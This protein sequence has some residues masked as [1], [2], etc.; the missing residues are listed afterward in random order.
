[1]TVNR[2]EGNATILNEQQSVQEFRD[3][4]T[5]TQRVVYGLAITTMWVGL[6]FLALG[7]YCVTRRFINA[8]PI[9]NNNLAKSMLFGLYGAALGYTFMKVPVF[10]FGKIWKTK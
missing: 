3:S 4:L 5:E 2:I 8:V 10:L 7:G 6:P 9:L 1:M